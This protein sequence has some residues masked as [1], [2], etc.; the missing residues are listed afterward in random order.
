MTIAPMGGVVKRG[1]PGLKLPGS[2]TKAFGLELMEEV[3][4]LSSMIEERG[5]GEGGLK[6]GSVGCGAHIGCKIEGVSGVWGPGDV[7]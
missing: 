4:P 3:A 2:E 7:V 1:C 6:R 5:G